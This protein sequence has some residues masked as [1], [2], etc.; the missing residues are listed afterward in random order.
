MIGPPSVNDYQDW[1]KYIWRWGFVLDENGIEVRDM[2]YR[3]ARF[4]F[5]RPVG[6]KQVDAALRKQA[7]CPS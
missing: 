1:Y 2:G 5:T 6:G 7:A 4:Y 3:R